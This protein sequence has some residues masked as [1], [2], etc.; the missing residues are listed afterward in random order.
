MLV[1]SPGDPPSG[2]WSHATAAELARVLRV[3]GA[4]VEWFRV[5]R[6]DAAEAAPG[7]LVHD[8][9][10]RER[11]LHDV[12]SANDDP[13]LE[14]ALARSL[15]VRP[16]TAVVHVGAGARGSPNVLWLA[17]RM[18]GA[19]FAVV[20]GAELVCH[21]GTLV[22]ARG[23][24]CS[25]FQ[26]AHRCQQCC[27]LSWWRRPRARAFQDRQDLL[28]GSLCVAAAVFVA[29]PHDAER[30]ATFGVPKRLLVMTHDATAIAVRLLDLRVT[31]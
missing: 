5:G 13:V 12:R 17:D 24:P 15:R 16:A 25:D 6:A 4:G 26:D 20:R 22:H 21:R 2:H 31:A 3:S 30:L 23:M 18:G 10:H 19:A 28:V 1:S 8:I 7:V 9:A 11:P 29:T 27:T 14:A